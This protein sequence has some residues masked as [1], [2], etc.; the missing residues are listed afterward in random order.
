[1]AQYRPSWL[2]AALQH[3]HTPQEEREDAARSQGDSARAQSA[4]AVEEKQETQG[5]RERPHT[6]QG[7]REHTERP[8]S[9]R[10]HTSADVSIRQQEEREDTERLQEERG[11]AGR[12]GVLEHEDQSTPQRKQTE[13]LEAAASAPEVAAEAE[14][15]SRSGGRGGVRE[16]KTKK[17]V[18]AV[19]EHPGEV[20]VGGA[21]GGH[22]LG[23]GQRGRGECVWIER[24]VHVEASECVGVCEAIAR[25]ARDGLLLRV[26]NGT[27]RCV[28]AL[29]ELN[30]ATRSNEFPMRATAFSS[31]SATARTGGLHTA[32]TKA[33]L[34][35]N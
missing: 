18:G 28:C 20:A 9:I 32:R 31:A 33:C 7:G 2:P 4:A 24:G 1:M 8:L 3:A 23:G 15:V 19:R 34:S 26:G 21:G 6:P 12:S 13:V 27:H 11:H 16:E 14:G 29:P 30:H 22:A 10:Q 5:K 25:A 35:T 17:S